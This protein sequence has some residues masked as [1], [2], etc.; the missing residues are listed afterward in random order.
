MTLDQSAPGAGN[1]SGTPVRVQ[2]GAGFAA[3]IA[4]AAI[5]IGFAVWSVAGLQAEDSQVSRHAVPY[6]TGLSDVAVA[7]KAAANDE[8]GFLLTGDKKYADEARGRRAVEKAGLTQ[9]SKAGVEGFLNAFRQEIAHLGVEVGVAY[10]PWLATDLVSGAD[11]HPAF[12]FFRSRL[13]SPFN[14]AYPVETATEALD[15]SRHRG[16]HCVGVGYVGLEP[17]GLRPALGGDALEL[18]GLE[19]DEREARPARRGQTRG[20]GADAARRARDED[21]LAVERSVC[22]H[23]RGPYRPRPRAAPSGVTLQ[24]CPLW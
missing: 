15:R 19:A 23:G 22:R 9:A 6:L 8:R 3:L 18:L 5:V 13:R 24:P 17:R 4:V 7:A 11:E 21:G 12:A 14:K 20:R 16:V 1:R 2:L 10:F